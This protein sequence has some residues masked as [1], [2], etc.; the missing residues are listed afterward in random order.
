MDRLHIKDA[1]EYRAYLKSTHWKQLKID[2]KR[3]LKKQG[4]KRCYVCKYKE[5]LH[6]HHRTYRRLGQELP[7]DLV[8]LCRRCHRK[9][10]FIVKE[11]K[12]TLYNAHVYL[13]RKLGF[14]E[15][16]QSKSVEYVI[17]VIP[18]R[19]FDSFGNPM[20][21]AEKETIK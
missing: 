6:L 12:S 15:S 20:P 11:R 19:K 1:K 3:K 13:R 8:C 14:V 7:D 21:D 16:D 17:T 10:H 18:E 2:T 9:V 5:K 4:L